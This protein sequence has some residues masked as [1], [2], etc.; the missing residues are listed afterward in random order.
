MMKR[1]LTQRPMTQRSSPNQAGFALPVMLIVLLVMLVSSIYLLKS[2]NTTTL[3]AANLAY[4]SAQSRAVDYGLHAGFKWLQATSTSKKGL[5]DT[6]APAAGYVATYDPTQGVRSPAFWAGSTIVTVG[7]QRI[8]Y[9]IRRM[10][11]YARPYNED[12]TCVQTSDN[13]SASGTA[14]APGSSMAVTTPRYAG[15]PRVHY[16]VTARI[17]GARGG[18]VVNQMTVLIGG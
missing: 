3:T 11:V 2:S 5:L 4:D 13:P 15:V 8:E 6:N 1:S 16:L 17:D 18:N 9:V 12:N 10:C 14:L 7:T